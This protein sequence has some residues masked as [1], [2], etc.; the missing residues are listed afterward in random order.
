MAWRRR[1]A[2]KQS[3][4]RG[5]TAHNDDQVPVVSSKSKGMSLPKDFR[6]RALTAPSGATSPSPILERAGPETRLRD[7]TATMLDALGTDAFLLCSKFLVAVFHNV[8]LFPDVKRYRKMT[9]TSQTVREALQCTE[10]A[11]LLDLV[12]FLTGQGTHYLLSEGADLGTLSLAEKALVAQR[13][14]LKV[15][16][17]WELFHSDVVR[18]TLIGAGEFGEIYSGKWLHHDVA[19]KTLKPKASEQ[20]RRDFVHEAMVM[21]DLHHAN[22]L[23]LHGVLMSKAP[24]MI[25][26]ELMEGDLQTQ[27]R[28]EEQTVSDKLRVAF[29]VAAGV[30][31]LHFNGI[32]HCDL[33][34]RNILL[35]QHGRCVISDFGLARRDGTAECDTSRCVFPISVRWSAPEV[36]KTRMVSRK[37]DVWSYGVVFYEVMTNG[38]TPYVT[39]RNARVRE[40]VCIRHK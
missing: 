19:I 1:A 13:K 20:A 34:T 40:E 26:M 7:L 33:A 30:E 16:E 27:L 35:A 22:V 31:Y 14:K 37:T 15:L 23:G 12:G 5:G 38:A 28:T 10:V 36:W 3:S 32:V 18:D 25:V 2:V 4:T 21:K 24:M 39:W 9:T 6:L 17:A 29:E 11:R 8:L